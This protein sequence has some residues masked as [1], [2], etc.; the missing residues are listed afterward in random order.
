MT[1]VRIF[2]AAGAIAA[3]AAM[4][5]GMLAITAP[6]ASAAPLAGCSSAV[7]Q[8]ELDIQSFG[9]LI[10]VSNRWQDVL[11]VVQADLQSSTGDAHDAFLRDEQQIDSNCAA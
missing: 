7:S 11:A 2:A 9:G 10:P 8:A 6:A 3:S 1:K 4:G 5:M